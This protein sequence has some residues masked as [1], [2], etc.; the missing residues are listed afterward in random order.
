MVN[1]MTSAPGPCYNR[2][3]VMPEALSSH[4]LPIEEGTEPA[5][6]IRFFQ[7]ELLLSSMANDVTRMM[8]SAPT[9]HRALSSL[10]NG[11]GEITGIRRMALLKLEGRNRRLELGQSMG[12][13]RRRFR[14]LDL[15]L[16]EGPLT[17]AIFENRHVIVDA[18]AGDDP[19]APAGIRSY[20]LI[21]LFSRPVKGAWEGPACE[22]ADCLA[23]K[24]P[25]HCGRCPISRCEGLLWLDITDATGLLTGM[26]ITYL[27]S[28]GQQAGIMLESFRIHKKLEEANDILLE[29][30]SKLGDANQALKLAQQRTN[31]ELEQA[32]SIQKSLLPKVFPEKLVSDIAARYLPA[33]KVGGDYYDCFEISPDR[34]ALVVADVSG[35]GIAAAL[36]MSMFKVLLKTFA[37]QHFSPSEVLKKINRI[38]LQEM[39]GPNFVTAFYATFEKSTRTL[40]YS[41]A[42]HVAQLLLP[43]DGEAAAD[44]ESQGLFIGVFDDTMLTD[45]CRVLPPHSRL[46][47]FTD[48]ITEAHGDG[49]ELFGYEK[50]KK[51]ALE[52]LHLAP[53]QAGENIMAALEFYQ[54][55]TPLADDVTLVILDL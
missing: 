17:T 53:A 39:S 27:H 43:R 9:V 21:P 28:L 40:R 25:P 33:G 34:M 47:L 30:N 36:I 4:S 51:L 52:S 3:Q 23:A 24:D 7:R 10:F 19:F 6:Q 54:G 2:N 37:P 38:F 48:G 50:L 11:L 29:T 46:I 22:T 35:H 18:A 8:M 45:G 44:L 13:R 20:V 15:Q 12:I 49:D 16:R 1:R 41:N 55:E 14:T 5:E 32:R 26:S 42:G 31:Q